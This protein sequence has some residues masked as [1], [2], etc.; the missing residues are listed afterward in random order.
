MENKNGNY[1][2]KNK[3]SKL[4]D[5]NEKCCAEFERI[6]SYLRQQDR[7]NFSKLERASLQLIIRRI[8]VE[9][10]PVHLTEM[11]RE[12]ALPHSM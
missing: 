12:R 11:T 2:V 3:G 4:V 6:S 9:I 1:E 8:S 5:E 10:D 7:S